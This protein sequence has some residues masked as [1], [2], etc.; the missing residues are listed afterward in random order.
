MEI[1]DIA[2]PPVLFGKDAQEVAAPMVEEFD[3]RTLNRRSSRERLPV[4]NPGVGSSELQAQEG[5]NSSTAVKVLP[6][7]TVISDNTY[8]RAE[9]SRSSDIR[10][11]LA[12]GTSVT[13]F[14]QTGAW[15]HVGANDGSSITGFVHKTNV[16][17]ADIKRW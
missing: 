3:Y 4:S 13:A 6:V 15:I 1:I 10:L 17:A 5:N 11:T 9:P 14:E 2:A 12:T 7:L 8:V 16:A